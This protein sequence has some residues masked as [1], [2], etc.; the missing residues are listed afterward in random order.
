MAENK[1]GYPRLGVSI[2]KSHGNA[3]KR[4]RLKRLIREVFRQCQE[5]IPSNYDC[6]IIIKKKIK[7]PTFGQVRKSFLALAASD[8]KM[9]EEN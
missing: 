7:Q 8:E 3:V 4:N 1:C 6:L 5:Q 2:S 9:C